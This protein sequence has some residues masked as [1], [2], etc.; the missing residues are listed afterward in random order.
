MDKKA[1]ELF[2]WEGE[3]QRARD[4]ANN[5]LKSGKIKRSSFCWLCGAMTETAMHHA[6]YS[7]P[8]C[9]THLCQACHTIADRLRQAREAGKLLELRQFDWQ[10]QSEIGN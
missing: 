5:M 6:R 1:G 8:Q 10:K 4:V 2:D 7:Q 3:R 9:V